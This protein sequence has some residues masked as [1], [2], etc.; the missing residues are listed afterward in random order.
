MRDLVFEECREKMRKAVAHLQDEF[1]GI[2]TGRATPGL[3]EKLKVDYYGTEVPL[4]QLAGCRL[5]EPRMLV[6]SPYDKG[7]MKA[8]EKAIQASDLGINPS[9]DGQVVRLTFPALTEDRRKELVKVVKH[10]AEEGRVAV[11]NIRRQARHDLEGL[12]R[13]G[14]LSR[15][16]L[17]RAEKELEKRT[18][19]VVE[20]MDQMLHHKEQELLEV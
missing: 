8:I 6:I 20:E 9:N 3:V 15:D 18:H 10:R 1:A 4:Q 5:P 7:A 2:R 13:D 12:E 19:D 14:E 16:E 11:R 17:D